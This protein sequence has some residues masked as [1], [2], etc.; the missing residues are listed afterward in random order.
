MGMNYEQFKQYMNM[1]REN[2]SMY[3]KTCTMCGS[4]MS[5]NDKNTIA[6]KHVCDDCYFDVLGVEIEKY[7]IHARIR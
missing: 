4:I 5:C 3:H 6:G 2:P 1:V 7:P